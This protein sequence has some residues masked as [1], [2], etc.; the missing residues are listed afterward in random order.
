MSKQTQEEQL[1]QFQE[2]LIQMEKAKRPELQRRVDE[3]CKLF[4]DMKKHEGFRNNLA[5]LDGVE[6]VLDDAY[7]R[8][9]HKYPTRSRDEDGFNSKW[10]Q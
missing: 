1:K 9:H 3:Y 10:F 4:V 2:K 7:F 8:V 6:R 5:D